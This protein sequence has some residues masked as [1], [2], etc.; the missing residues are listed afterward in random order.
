MPAQKKFTFKILLTVNLV[1]KNVQ[2]TKKS[3]L[4]LRKFFSPFSATKKKAFV[5]NHAQIIFP[6]YVYMLMQWFFPAR[7][8]IF[9]NN[10]ENNKN[11]PVHKQSMREINF[12][13]LFKLHCG[14][15]KSSEFNSLV[16]FYFMWVQQYFQLSTLK[17]WILIKFPGIVFSCKSFFLK[18][19][20]KFFWVC[21]VLKVRK[22]TRSWKG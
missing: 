18:K 11:Q 19:S 9:S 8:L 21:L 22:F 4:L 7:L 6:I 13:Q 10:T 3:N 17:V 20:K 2:P 12:I 16:L 1:V 14:R 15:K 5:L